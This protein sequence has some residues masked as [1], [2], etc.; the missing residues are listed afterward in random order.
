MNAEL[1]IFQFTINFMHAFTKI[2]ICGE[3]VL[4]KR[5][6]ELKILMPSIM[7]HIGTYGGERC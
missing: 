4:R 2:K 3:E 7:I 5:R 6:K 1:E